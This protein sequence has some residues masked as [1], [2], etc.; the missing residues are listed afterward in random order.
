MDSI[1]SITLSQSMPESVF[2]SINTQLG[3]KLGK[4]ISRSTLFE[5]KVWI[6]KFKTE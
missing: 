3:P 1:R 6:N 5:N 2:K 4:R